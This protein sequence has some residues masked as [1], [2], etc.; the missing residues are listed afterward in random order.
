MIDKK[1]IFHTI[2]NAVGGKP[3]VIEYNDNSNVSKIEIYI[4]ED[5]PDKGV[6]TYATIGLSNFSIGLE[7]EDKKNIRVEF[8]GA[9]DTTADKFA[10]IIGSCAFNIINSKF[11][12]KPG[13][14]YPNVIKE[15]YPDIDMKHIF[16]T[17]PFLWDNL[18]GFEMDD[19]FITWLMAIPISNDEFEFL[20]QN[21]VEALERLLKEKDID[22]FDINR[23]SVL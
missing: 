14:A 21:G 15:Y 2:H 20:A 4:G 23:K 16:F 7:T 1:K 18:H 3:C 13:T 22:V 10:N 12:C 11:S 19:T 17:M 9:C 6:S 8:I 5:R